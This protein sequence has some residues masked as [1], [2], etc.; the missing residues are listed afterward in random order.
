MSNSF[1]LFLFFFF[2]FACFMHAVGGVTVT[3]ISG[4][5]TIHTRTQANNNNNSNGNT[6]LYAQSTTTVII[7]SETKKVH[8]N[9]FTTRAICST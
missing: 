3:F 6:V 9:L 1:F 4:S 2:C 5:D 8:L 7:I